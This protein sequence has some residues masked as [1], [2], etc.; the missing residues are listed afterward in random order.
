M[1]G[2]NKLADTKPDTHKYD[3]II[4]LPHP[5]SSRHPQ[6]SLHDRAAQFSPFAALTG[7]DAAVKETARLTEQRIEL[8]ESSKSLLD[9]KLG[10]VQEQLDQKPEITITYFKPDPKKAGGSYVEV[11]GSI[12]K[13]DE[14]ERL[15]VLC[16]GE[17]IPI[18]EV[19]AVQGEI[20]QLLESEIEY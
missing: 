18:D 4:N 13:I 8:D 6:M 3:D 5:V 16:S 20:F 9:E 15:L 11:A 17:K 10:I 19:I 2:I 14:Y 7:Y 1:N 12:K